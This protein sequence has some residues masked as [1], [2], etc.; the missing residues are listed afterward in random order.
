L[1]FQAICYRGHDPRW[2]HSPLSGEGAAVRGGRFN[3]QGVPALYVSLTLDT[4]LAEQ[5]HGFANRLLPLTICS[6]DVDVDDIIDLR[7]CTAARF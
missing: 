3:P 2:A 4:L 6:Y 5:G 7:T 1:R